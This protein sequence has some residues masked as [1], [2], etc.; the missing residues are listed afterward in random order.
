[1][2]ND[3]FTDELQNAGE[4]A[5]TWMERHEGDLAELLE[6]GSVEIE[7]PRNNEESKHVVLTLTAHYSESIDDKIA[8]GNA[9]QDETNEDFV[10]RV[11]NFSKSGPLAQLMIVEAIR[12]YS[13]LVMKT[14]PKS[15]PTAVLNPLAWHQCATEIYQEW[16]RKYGK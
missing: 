3:V 10:R 13:D 8:L 11:M 6:T 15:D 9:T 16:Y 4:D 5:F 7:F 1:M 12:F 2:S 14:E